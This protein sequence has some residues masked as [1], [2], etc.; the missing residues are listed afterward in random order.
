MTAESI[1]QEIVPPNGFQG[2]VNLK[3]TGGYLIDLCENERWQMVLVWIVIIS[4]F[5]TTLITIHATRDFSPSALIF[6]LGV[7]KCL[8]RPSTRLDIDDT[9][10][11][12]EGDWVLFKNR[13]VFQKDEIIDVIVTDI[14]ARRSDPPRVIGHNIRI[15]LPAG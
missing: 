9:K 3:P 2:R 10:L 6:A 4:L 15:Q 5:V 14:R 13:A 1:G 7:A 12:W 11:V 8:L